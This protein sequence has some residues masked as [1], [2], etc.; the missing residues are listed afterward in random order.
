V[1]DI[2]QRIVWKILLTVAAVSTIPSASGAAEVYRRAT[3]LEDL[4]G[5]VH[6]RSAY[7][8]RL[9]VLSSCE[10]DPGGCNEEQ[11]YDEI[12]RLDFISE[13]R[14]LVGDE[15]IRTEE[16][17]GTIHA[18]LAFSQ[19]NLATFRM[20]LRNQLQRLSSQ[21]FV[22]AF[23]GWRPGITPFDSTIAMR[24]ERPTW[25]CFDSRKLSAVTRFDRKMQEGGG[26]STGMGTYHEPPTPVCDEM[27]TATEDLHADVVET[28][29]VPRLLREITV[30]H[31]D[32]V[33][34]DSRSS[35]FLAQRPDGIK[36][37]RQRVAEGS[38]GESGGSDGTGS[39][40]MHVAGGLRYYAYAVP[41]PMPIEALGRNAWLHRWVIE[42]VERRLG[43]EP[44][45]Q[46][47][48]QIVLQA[49][50]LA[51]VPAA[52]IESD[53]KEIVLRVPFE[54]P[55]AREVLPNGPAE[56]DRRAFL[57]TL[58]NRLDRYQG[59][60]H[61]LLEQL[62]ARPEAGLESGA[63]ISVLCH[64]NGSAT[65]YLPP[66]KAHHR[67]LNNDLFCGAVESELQRS[68]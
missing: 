41:A 47:T 17:V 11:V 32:V 51:T 4:I 64:E 5:K 16:H 19:D 21:A 53:Q 66:T 67:V 43:P 49:A 30:Y 34:I 39:F 6:V 68:L 15:I 29:A 46:L 9:T 20:D 14:R 37:I 18:A 50:Y 38:T 52:V 65:Y 56:I 35:E 42:T 48:G 33:Q 23:A 61:E 31:E 60:P 26:R 1:D 2:L 40:A 45:N 3:I 36:F 12:V 62:L 22:Q 57:D 44:T 28:L 54:V 7:G 10:S 55:S 63:W 59:Q 25:V 13:R 8:V 27:A 24:S 58:V